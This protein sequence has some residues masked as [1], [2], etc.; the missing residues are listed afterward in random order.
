MPEPEPTREPTQRPTPRPTP[1]P[2][3]E[4]TRPPTTQAPGLGTGT[5][6]G[7]AAQGREAVAWARTQIGKTYGWGSSGPEAF[8]C[9]G[10][11]MRAW[12]AAGV[13]ITRTSRSQYLR[14]KKIQY[15]QMRPGDLIF[16]ANDTSDPGTIRHVA[17]YTGGGMMVEAARPGIPVREV[18]VHY[19]DSMPYAGRP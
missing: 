9:S 12:E 14:V 13:G 1:T 15:S 11:T 3:P 10:L 19:A 7:S 18:P 2:T 5:A 17:M 16:W 8:D 6:V 4:P